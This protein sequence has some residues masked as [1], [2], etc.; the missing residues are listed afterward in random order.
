MIDIDQIKIAIGEGKYSLG[1]DESNRNLGFT[2]CDF[3]KLKNSP[4]TVSRNCILELN[5][6]GT[7]CGP[8]LRLIVLLELRE[9][10]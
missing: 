8:S 7:I 1:I 3:I 10:W 4:K 9:I 2:L 6:S 5:F